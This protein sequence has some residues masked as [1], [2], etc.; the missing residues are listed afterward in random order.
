M[1]EADRGEASRASVIIPARDAGSLIGRTVRAVVEQE[2]GVDVEVIVVDDGSED[3]T[4][5]LARD[6]GARVIEMPP[7]A[8]RGNP[9][10]ARNRGAAAATGDPLIFL[11]ADCVPAA[12]WL[13]RLLAAHAAGERCVGGSLALPPGLTA[14]AR[15]DY[16]CGWYHAHP[17]R[18]RGYVP[19]H[20]PGN[21]S[22]RRSDFAAT[23]GFTER[24]PIAYA[25]EELGW[26]KELQRAGGR[27]LFE[28]AA[29]VHHWNRP[30]WGNALR[31]NYR[32]GYSAIESKAG[33]GTVRAAWLYRFPRLL[34]ALSLPLAPFQATYVVACWLRAGVLEPL[35]MSP[36]VLAARLAYSAGMTIGGLRWLRRRRSPAAAS[37]PR[38]G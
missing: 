22:V 14:S 9:A 37:G 12:A 13:E 26:Q 25:H 17:R 11:D 3:D 5:R 24:Q 1:G 6:A 10:A 8:S 19:N 38:W 28:P 29:V 21:L 30:G 23:G 20:P 18:P 34:I 31:R 32:W 16:Y 2:S 4:A 33:A 35:L 27:I 7:G 15:C 36:A